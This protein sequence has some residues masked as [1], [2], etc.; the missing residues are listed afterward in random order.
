MEK[1]GQA[2]MEF[3]MT[4]GWAI[5]VVLIAIGTLAFFGVLNPAKFLPQSCIL[6]PGLACE[7]FKV[8]ASDETIYMNVRNG[9]GRDLDVFLIYVDKKTYNGN[10]ICGGM[11]GVIAVPTSLIIPGSDLY[12][13]FRDGTAR[14]L[15]SV[16][17]SGTFP[18]TGLGLNCDIA[19]ASQNCCS[20]NTLPRLACGTSTCM[21]ENYACQVSSPLPTKAG[22]KFSQDIVIV[23]RERGSSILHQRIG[24]ITA[25]TE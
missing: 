3:L 19:S 15:V 11:T 16:P 5:L 2:A 8:V 24:R 22:Q 23:Y 17:T 4:Y 1:K 7:D 12:P 21:C 25:S 14:P 9:L 18:P 20:L 10:E 6:G 13:A